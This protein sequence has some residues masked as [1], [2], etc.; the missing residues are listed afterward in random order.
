MALPPP[1]SSATSL[2][3]LDSKASSTEDGD[4]FLFLSRYPTIAGTAP[5]PLRGMAGVLVPSLKRTFLF[6]G[7]GVDTAGART[8]CS[9][10]L[11]A[12][13]VEANAWT[14]TDCGHS[15]SKPSPR[16]SGSA[17]LLGENVYFF[18]GN[19]AGALMDDLFILH[20]HDMT[21]SRACRNA[22]S[23][24]APT[25]DKS[26]TP[27]RR[28]PLHARPARVHPPYAF[29]LAEHECGYRRAWVHVPSTGPT[30]FG[31]KPS[32]RQEHAAAALDGR[33]WLFGGGTDGG[34][35]QD[36]W[37]F[38]PTHAQW[39]DQQPAGDDSCSRSLNTRATIASSP[40]APCHPTK[41]PSCHQ[42]SSFT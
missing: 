41:L 40:V 24:S 27:L 34:F 39:S 2:I 22:L 11:F 25:H 14:C 26:R 17:T 30:I 20:T 12:H 16:E 6:G 38:D 7:C 29:V 19:A 15:A 10:D 3:Q 4:E 33:L 5:P 23:S 35:L 28:T 18:G 31:K 9:A 8:D 1:R 42:P 36:L 13:S 37:A 32:P 21:W